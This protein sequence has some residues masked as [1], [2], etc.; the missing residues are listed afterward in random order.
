MVP[1][2]LDTDQL[3]WFSDV[4]DIPCG[5]KGELISS[6]QFFVVRRLRGPLP[7]E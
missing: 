5:N 7:L 3:S 4:V 2:D 6:Y 1:V